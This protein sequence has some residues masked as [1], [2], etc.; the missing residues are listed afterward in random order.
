MRE[1][2]INKSDCVATFNGFLRKIS[3]NNTRRRGDGENYGFVGLLRATKCFSF[4]GTF[5]LDY[6]FVG[7]VRNF[8]QQTRS[9]SNLLRL[10]T[11]G[12]ACG[13]SYGLNWAVDLIAMRRD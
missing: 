3:G 1:G 10:A 6:P 4:D 9:A 7:T 11:C 12:R 2:K 13:R 5:N 8:L